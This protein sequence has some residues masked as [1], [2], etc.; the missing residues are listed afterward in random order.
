MKGSTIPH[1]VTGRYGSAQVLLKP[2]SEGT[3]VIAGGPV[4][5][6]MQVAGIHNVL[7]KSLGTSNPHNVVKA[8]FAALLSLKDAGQVAETRSKTIEEISGR[9]PKA[10]KLVEKAA[11]E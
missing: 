4:R 8:T 9:P 3:G 5:K 10:E 7:T 6:V 1:Q 2:A 11:G